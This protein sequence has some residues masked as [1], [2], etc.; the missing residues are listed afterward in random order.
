M[1][2]RFPQMPPY[3][4]RVVVPLDFAVLDSYDALAL[5]SLH[6]GSIQDP[7]VDRIAA[8]FRTNLL[9]R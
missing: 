9:W 6:R 8:D 3:T 5:H 7:A 1:I 4:V 2:V